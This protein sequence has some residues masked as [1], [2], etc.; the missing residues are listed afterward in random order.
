MGVTTMFP[1][2][3][4]SLDSIK[5]NKK[6][7]AEIN[8]QR[9]WQVKHL[10]KARE[11]FPK[12]SLA[13]KADCVAWCVLN[14]RNNLK[15]FLHVKRIFFQSVLPSNLFLFLYFQGEEA[16]E[17]ATLY[18][19]LKEKFEPAMS[20]KPGTSQSTTVKKERKKTKKIFFHLFVFFPFSM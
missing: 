10:N 8:D 17:V 14:V 2:I 13:T 16:T 4:K 1:S 11:C 5:N 6:R 15:I 12:E 18:K 9:R 3:L 19:K 20:D 7:Q